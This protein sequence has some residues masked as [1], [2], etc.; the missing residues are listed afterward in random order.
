M[1][2]CTPPP[3]GSLP[4]S[5]R[6][7]WRVSGGMWHKCLVR[8][9]GG[10]LCQGCRTYIRRAWGTNSCIRSAPHHHHHRYSTPSHTSR[11]PHWEWYAFVS[12]SKASHG[13][14][15]RPS[16]GHQPTP[17]M[18]EGR[19]LILLLLDLGRGE[20][21]PASFPVDCSQG[22]HRQ[23]S[24]CL[25]LRAVFAACHRTWSPGEGIRIAVLSPQAVILL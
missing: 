22:G 20:G 18:S 12:A 4:A 3:R 13:R 6:H 7:T 8:C 25:L 11:S 21:E 10:G 15:L 2:R 16:S 5:P 17:H 9:L 14:P 19:V 23:L 1:R 24:P